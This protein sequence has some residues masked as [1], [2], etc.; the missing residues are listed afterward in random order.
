MNTSRIF[1]AVLA[2]ALMAGVS[3]CKKPDEPVGPA[4]KAGAAIDNAGVKVTE[5][6]KENLDKARDTANEA[7]KATGDRI[8]EATEDASK[9]LSTATENVG[10]KVEK[11]GEKIQE[12]ARPK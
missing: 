12:A 1:P 11:A 3:A 2:L 8:N 10:K 7:S 4:Q 9:G 5:A 6:I